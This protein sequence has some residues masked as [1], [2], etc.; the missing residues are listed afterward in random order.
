MTTFK[1]TKGLQN[2]IDNM[3]ESAF[4]EK[5]SEAIKKETCIF[6]KQPI[7]SFRDELSRREYSISGLCQSCQDEIF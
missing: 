3:S 1:R 5:Q 6:C 4:G 2:V 7:D